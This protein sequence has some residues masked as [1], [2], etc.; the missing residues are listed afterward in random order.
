MKNLKQLVAAIRQKKSSS[1][2]LNLDI[3]TEENISG[4]DDLATLISESKVLTRISFW[5]SNL[6]NFPMSN[7]KAVESLLR[8][9]EAISKRDEELT[10][11][12]GGIDLG[13]NL[14][15]STKILPI[16]MRSKGKLSLDLGSTNLYLLLEHFPKIFTDIS[17]SSIVELDLDANSLGLAKPEHLNFLWD[18]FLVHCPNLEKLTIHGDRLGKNSNIIKFFESLQNLKK[19]IKLGLTGNELCDLTTINANGG[20]N[21]NNTQRKCLSLLA[22]HPSIKN[23]DVS[24][25]FLCDFSVTDVK[26]FLDTILN[27][28]TINYLDINLNALGDMQDLD[29]DFLN[30]FQ[31][32][33][34]KSQENDL[35]I[36]YNRGNF[37]N[38]ELQ[39]IESFVKQNSDHKR[40]HPAMPID[41]NKNTET[42]LLIAN[43][44]NILLSNFSI[45]NTQSTNLSP[46]PLCLVDASLHN[47][48]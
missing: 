42:G 46:K 33:I 32:V 9:F 14:E 48:T 11:D 4:L 10:I 30:Y 3:T 43:S 2:L 47:K 44:K 41:H 18:Y 38:Y 19:L 37:E 35:K 45:W 34:K 24:C 21:I 25:N 29:P 26:F 17:E 5:T 7:Q 23:L 20:E 31:Q 40:E 8:V 36:I 27:K 39:E 12:L 16:L 1:I 6:H 15:L 13:H 22:N 28:K